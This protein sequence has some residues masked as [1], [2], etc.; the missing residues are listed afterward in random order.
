MNGWSLP[1]GCL[2]LVSGALLGGLFLAIKL[3]RVLLHSGKLCT[4][5]LD[6]AFCLVCA[7]TAFL[8]A[9]VVDKGRLRLF[10]AALQA[11]GAWG[12]I[13]A[14]DPFISGVAR[15]LRRTWLWLCAA[16]RKAVFRWVR[17]PLGR[18]FGWGKARMGRLIQRLAARLRPKPRHPSKAKASARA[19]RSRK[20]A[21]RP[22]QKPAANHGQASRNTRQ[23]EKKHRR[24]EKSKKTS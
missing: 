24:Y 22:G 2:C 11:L 7:L 15:W 1:A 14:L 20:K 3:L 17:R 16:V 21:R 8:C 12:V 18:L 5:L 23:N 9:L 10:Q 13:A 6:V 19:G 4:A